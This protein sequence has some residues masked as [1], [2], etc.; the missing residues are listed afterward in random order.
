LKYWPVALPWLVYLAGMAL[1]GGWVIDDA[2]ISFAYARNLG[3]GDGFVAQPGLP[4]VEGF[5]NLSWVILLAPLARWSWF[6]PTVA[7]KLLGAGLMLASLLMLRRQLRGAAWWTVALLIALSPPLVIWTSSGLENG[8]M[9]LLALILWHLLVEDVRHFVAGVVA[10]LMAATHPEGLLYVLALPLALRRRA[11]LRSLAGWAAVVAPLFALRLAI[12]HLP[13]PHTFYA[14]RIHLTP[15]DRLMDLATHPYATLEQ[16]AELATG[17][18]GPAGPWLWAAAWAALI[19]FRRALPRWLTVA[20]TLQLVGVA[21]YLWIDPDWM[22]EFRFAT[23]PVAM[24]ALVLAGAAGLAIPRR[25][26]ATLLLVVVAAVPQIPRLW[27]FALDPPTP[28]AEVDRLWGQKLEAWKRIL[29]LKEGS[30]FL[31]DVGAPLWSSSLRILD[32]AGLCEPAIVRTLKDGTPEWKLRSPAFYDW[33]FETARPTFVATHDFWTVVSQL[34]QDPRLLRDYVAIDAYW[35]RYAERTYGVRSRSGIWVRRDALT[36]PDALA[37]LQAV[38]SSARRETPAWRLRER[39]RPRPRADLRTRAEALD[40]ASRVDEARAIWEQLRGDPAARDRLEG[41]NR[42]ADEA[43]WMNDGVAALYGANDPARALTL[44]QKILAQ[45]PNH[46]GASFQLARA[47]TRVG[48]RDEARAAWQRALEL[49]RTIHD[50]ATTEL[51]RAEL[52]A[53]PPP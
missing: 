27:R 24:S 38:R 44:F 34:D 39:F 19:L 16:L 10:G 40:A 14:K 25:P 29:N 15:W 5:S 47:L 23:V 35:D 30:A 37:Q 28:L 18:G 31:A 50:E 11:L 1:L 22:G 9:L 36:A 33:F 49:A 52:S 6:D 13:L 2:G 26:Q 43:H 4:A 42:E 51:I 48:K 17:A 46:Y 7:S 32:A 41:F 3:R 20:A 21:A 8:L 45:N 53:L 12:F